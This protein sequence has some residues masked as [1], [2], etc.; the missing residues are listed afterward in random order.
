MKNALPGGELIGKEQAD[1]ADSEIE[2]SAGGILEIVS[3]M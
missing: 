2:F 1:S 3:A